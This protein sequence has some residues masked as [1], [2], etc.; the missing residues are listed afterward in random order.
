MM[1]GLDELS[2]EEKSQVERAVDLM[3]RD[4]KA[5]VIGAEKLRQMG[6]RVGDRMKMTSFNYKGLEFDF[7]VVAEF[8]SGSRWDNSAV[9][10]RKYLDRAGGMRDARAARIR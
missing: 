4:P 2:G 6:K 10:N 9:M 5:V 1:P 3:S 7:I 8:P